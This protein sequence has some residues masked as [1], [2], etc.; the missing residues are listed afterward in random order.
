M[1]ESVL[2]QLYWFMQITKTASHLQFKNIYLVKLH[3]IADFWSLKLHLTILLSGQ[4]QNWHLPCTDAV[5]KMHLKGQEKSGEWTLSS[6]VFTP[7]LF[8]RKT[9]SLYYNHLD[10]V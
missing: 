1:P 9:S 4:T 10:L 6:Q 5:C 2:R 7:S 8:Q 3:F